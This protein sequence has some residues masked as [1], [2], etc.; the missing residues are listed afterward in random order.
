[1]TEGVAPA[2]LRACGKALITSASPP[3]LACGPIS[4]ATM[5]ILTTVHPG[6]NSSRLDPPGQQADNKA[7]STI[8]GY[9]S[10]PTSYLRTIM[11]L[12]VLADEP[13][14][15]RIGVEHPQPARCQN[16]IIIR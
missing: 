3:T 11:R 10:E 5:A 2:F 7:R 15:E 6:K 14:C 1:M 12:A 16:G 4:A 9:Q 8:C 13:G